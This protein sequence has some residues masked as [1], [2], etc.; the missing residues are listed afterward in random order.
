MYSYMKDKVLSGSL[1]VCSIVDILETHFGPGPDQF[2]L[3]KKCATFSIS[4]ESIF[5]LLNGY[6]LC[7][8]TEV[9]PQEESAIRYTIK[10]FLFSHG[11]FDRMS[12]L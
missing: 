7:M 8:M 11:D 5:S 9:H 10:S 3:E 4:P 1:S 6:F 2:C 12:C